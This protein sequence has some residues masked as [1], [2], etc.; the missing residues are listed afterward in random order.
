M[1]QQQEQTQPT[2]PQTRQVYEAPALVEYGQLRA[3]I[4]AGQGSRL[5]QTYDSFPDALIVIEEA[6]A[7]GTVRQRRMA[8][9]YVTSKYTSQDILDKAT[10]FEANYDGTLWVAD[11]ARTKQRVEGLVGG[12]CACLT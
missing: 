6:F 2:P 11:K 5:G 7:D 12:S 3:A 10:S 8:V 9:E 4:Q 1:S